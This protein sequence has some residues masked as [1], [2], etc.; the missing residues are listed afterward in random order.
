M[1]K[2]VLK[3]KDDS[4]VDEE[5]FDVEGEEMEMDNKY[6]ENSKD[7]EMV[8]ANEDESEE[9]SEDDDEDEDEM[10]D[11][12]QEGEDEEEEEQ[13]ELEDLMDEDMDVFDA[14]LCEIFKQRKMEKTQRKGIFE[15]ATPS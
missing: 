3:N 11:E 2:K 4:P 6:L 7:Q 12:A 14:K 5:I 10:E 13:M 15:S 9:A 1:K 8:E